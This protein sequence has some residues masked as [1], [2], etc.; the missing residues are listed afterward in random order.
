MLSFLFSLLDVM[1][2]KFQLFIFWLLSF[3][4]FHLVVKSTSG[5]HICALIGCRRYREIGLLSITWNSQHH[6]QLFLSSPRGH[7]YELNRV[8]VASEWMDLSGAMMKNLEKSPFLAALGYVR[9]QT[10]KTVY[11]VWLDSSGWFQKQKHILLLITDKTVFSGNFMYY[12]APEDIQ[13]KKQMSPNLAIASYPINLNRLTGFLIS[14]GL[15]CAFA[16]RVS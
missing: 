1:F 13:V 16:T 5:E 14:S 11:I 6:L 10:I 4:L 7:Y 12:D 9:G 15:F 3:L 8:R 2:F